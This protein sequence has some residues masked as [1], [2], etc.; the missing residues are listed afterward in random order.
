LGIPGFRR[1]DIG[2]VVLLGIALAAFKLACEF[3]LRVAGYQN[4]PPPPHLTSLPGYVGFSVLLVLVLFALQSRTREVTPGGAWKSWLVIVV[5]LVA[6]VLMFPAGVPQ[7][8]PLRALITAIGTGG[9]AWL[10][11]IHRRR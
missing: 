2:I 3:F 4:A 1:G 6:F 8:D 10:L 9:A 7:G 5:I 11:F